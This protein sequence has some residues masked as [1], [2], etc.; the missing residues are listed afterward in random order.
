MF[1]PTRKAPPPGLGQ[2]VVP[3][4]FM[5]ISELN[6]IW[7]YIHNIM[8]REES[9]IQARRKQY[10][11][12]THCAMSSNTDSLAMNSPRLCTGDLKGQC[13]VHI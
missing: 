11:A 13:L 7:T 1:S 4:H 2:V 12:A 3:D 8:E 6:C 5:L 9:N 10:E